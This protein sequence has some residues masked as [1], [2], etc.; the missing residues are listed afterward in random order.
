MSGAGPRRVLIVRRG[1]IERL[2]RMKTKFK[3]L[4]VD[5]VIDRRHEDR[6]WREAAG[7]LE[8]RRHDRRAAWPQRFPSSSFLVVPA[9]L[10]DERIA[11]ARG[12]A[13]VSGGDGARPG[14]AYGLSLVPGPIQARYDSYET[15][16]ELARRFAHYASTDLWYTE[17]ELTFILLDAFRAPA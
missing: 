11:P 2:H 6:R 13:L 17:D 4:P 8:R 15:A 16:V 12:D 1:D 7:A 9:S 5:V 3:G 10:V 14:E